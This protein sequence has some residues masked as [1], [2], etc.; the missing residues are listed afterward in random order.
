MST[1]LDSPTY[2]GRHPGCGHIRMAIVDNEP[3]DPTVAR[4]VAQGITDGLTIE[5]VTSSVV[6]A[7]GFGSCEACDPRGAARRVQEA[8]GQQLALGMPA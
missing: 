1:D 8:A 4:W 6:R 2:I 3:G 7:E 5:R